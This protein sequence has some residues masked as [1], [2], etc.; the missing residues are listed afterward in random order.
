MLEYQRTNKAENL[1]EIG[2]NIMASSVRA[3]A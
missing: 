1:R 2:L 3:V